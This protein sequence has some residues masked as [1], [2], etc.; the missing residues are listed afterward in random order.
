MDFVLASN[1]HGMDCSRLLEDWRWLIPYE[2][3]PLQVGIFGDWIFGMANGAIWHLSLLDGVFQE[4]SPDVR[5]YNVA[6]ASPQNTADWF[7][8]EWAEIAWARGLRPLENECL[9]WKVAPILGGPF[10]FENMQV[11]SPF[12]YQSLMG[13]LFK[14]LR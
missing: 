10:S 9:G 3:E 11:F 4:I 1:C 14:Q 2:A 12:V 8:S 7:C 13:Q 5:A 6:K